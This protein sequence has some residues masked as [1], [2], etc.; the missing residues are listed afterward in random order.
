MIVGNTAGFDG[1]GINC[2]VNS[3]VAF[4]N[5]T[6]SRNGAGGYGGGF[7][8]GWYTS[9]KLTN[10]ILWGDTASLD[11]DEAYS[12]SE[13]FGIAY[14]DVD[15]GWQGLGNIDTDPLFR[16]DY[17]LMSRECGDSLDS[18]CIDAGSPNISDN[19]LDCLWGLGTAASDVGAFGGGNSSQPDAVGVYPDEAP[20]PRKLAV[21]Q[22]YPNPF[23]SQTEISYVVS[24]PGRVTLEIFD[25]L[26][27]RIEAI[28]NEN[29][30]AGYHKIAWDATGLPSGVYFYRI[31][32][33]EFS[34]TRRMLLVK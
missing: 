33:G 13:T 31:S 11:G 29:Q 1:G 3:E 6:L 7:F 22:N 26:G 17:R 16:P 34:A 19:F 27:R 32:D 25:I 8:S 15:G 23:N 2:T 18:P 5:N 30:Q 24:R 28:T 14:S 20:A 4:V 10:N 21:S 9:S 12:L